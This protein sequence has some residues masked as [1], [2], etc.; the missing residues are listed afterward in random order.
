MRSLPAISLCAIV[1]TL[2]LPPAS[3]A[4]PAD[5]FR[6]V[7]PLMLVSASLDRPDTEA[8]L[9]YFDENPV[10]E[11]ARSTMWGA[12][13]GTIL[14]LAAAVVV[15]DGGEA[16]KWGFVAG[17]F[18]GFLWGVVYAT[19]RDAS[20][21]AGPLDEREFAGSLPPAFM[22]SRDPK[23]L[24]AHGGSSIRIPLLRLALDGADSAR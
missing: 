24:R 9:M 15:E 2:A 3:S 4:Q 17:T 13:G 8:G 5:T 23:D 10:V 11:V 16:V 19:G 20:Q 12:I 21:R 14:G 18:G 22:G 1:L 6:P 7:S